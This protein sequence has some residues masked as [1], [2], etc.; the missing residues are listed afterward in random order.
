MVQCS[1]LLEEL[2]DVGQGSGNDAAVCVSLSTS[3]DRERLPA[4]RL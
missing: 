3:R 2:E 4:A 1:D